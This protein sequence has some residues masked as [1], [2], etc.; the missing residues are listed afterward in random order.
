MPAATPQQAHSLVNVRSGQHPPPFKLALFP[1]LSFPDAFRCSCSS[2]LLLG[3]SFFVVAVPR[4][5]AMNHTSK[6]SSSLAA[7]TRS[8]RGRQ[9]PT[10]Q[11]AEGQEKCAITSCPSVETGEPRPKPGHTSP[12]KHG[13]APN[14]TATRGKKGKKKTKGERADGSSIRFS[15]FPPPRPSSLPRRLSVCRARRTAT[16]L[17]RKQGFAAQATHTH[18]PPQ[19]SHVCVC[20]C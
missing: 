15:S 17:C 11:Q 5:S 6:L 20:V 18:T 8:P 14:K 16:L 3:F 19:K 12:G 10:E 1:F 4:R 9:A 7:A 13:A 2:L